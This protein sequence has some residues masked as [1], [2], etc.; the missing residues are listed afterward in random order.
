MECETCISPYYYFQFFYS[1]V[2]TFL[3][4]NNCL[5]WKLV[6]PVME[7]C[8]WIHKMI[9]LGYTCSNFSSNGLKQQNVCILFFLDVLSILLLIM[10]IT[11]GI[12][13]LYKRQLNYMCD[14]SITWSHPFFPL[15][16][17]IILLFN[18]LMW[19]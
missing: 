18:I 13:Y 5:I 10:L 9:C 4:W 11:A 1:A 7:W 19:L 17:S 12:P 8:Q 15:N 6:L 14:I 16:L 3:A 2:N